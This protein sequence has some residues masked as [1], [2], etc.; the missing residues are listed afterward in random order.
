MTIL[1]QIK[2]GRLVVVPRDP[3]DAMIETAYDVLV[4]GKEWGRQVS[5]ADVFAAM[6]AAS[7]DHTTALV[8]LVEGMER[9]RDETAR[10]LSDPLA[11]HINMVRGTIA[12]PSI[13]N[14]RHI[15]PEIAQ[16]EFE[17][18]CALRAAEARALAAEAER[19]ALRALICRVEPHIDAIVCY[20]S[21]MGEHEP[22]RIAHEV[23]SIASGGVLRA[24]ETGWLIELRGS[25]P[26]WAIVNPRDYDEHWT[27]DSTRALRF[28]RREDAQAYIDHI[29]WTEA[30]PS[31][32][33]WDD[34]RT[35][36][37]ATRTEQP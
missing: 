16:G 35:H 12:K 3:D 25:A 24:A 28:A 30:F 23:R 8:A 4:D 33:I 9:E 20:A 36:S 10:Q 7:P 11:V 22:N 29:G 1:D 18:R 32:H 34:G 2:T 14:I 15:Y 37:D 19:D 26:S 27:A 31:E 17:A 5:G 21:A 6:L 13:E